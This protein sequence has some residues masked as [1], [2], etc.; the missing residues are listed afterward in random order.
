MSDRSIDLKKAD[1]WLRAFVYDTENEPTA[2]GLD[3]VE[4]EG[5][6]YLKTCR[7]PKCR[8][9]FRHVR[10][11]GIY[12]CGKCGAA[13]GYRDTCILKGDVQRSRVI[14]ATEKAMLAQIR[15]GVPTH[16]ALRE[17]FAALT[18]DESLKWSW[19]IYVAVAAGRASLADLASPQGDR[20]LPGISTLGVKK[21]AMHRRYHEGRTAWGA[22]LR[23][24]GLI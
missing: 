18:K 4:G 19:R 3:P 6:R 5:R 15:E 23:E 1:E 14:G 9:R 7:A 21:T 8:G 10:N 17:A 24:A 20:V 16:W 13:W 22:K 2:P 11:D 12:V